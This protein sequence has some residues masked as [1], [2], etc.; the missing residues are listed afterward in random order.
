ME[1]VKRTSEYTIV[2]KRNGRYGVQAK[3]RNWVNADEKVKILMEA[4]LIKAPEPKPAEP[5]PVAEEAP[6]EEAAEGEE[7]AAE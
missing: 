5:E 4:G 1:I 7:Q 2:K 6:A 3:G